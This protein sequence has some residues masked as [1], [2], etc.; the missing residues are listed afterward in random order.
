MVEYFLT[1]NLLGHF[2][3]ILQQRSNRRG[4]VAMQVPHR[5]VQRFSI[6]ACAVAQCSTVQSSAVPC[7]RWQ[8]RGRHIAGDAQGMAAPVAELRSP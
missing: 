3:Q 2:N 6:A 4:N 8:C 7:S 5:V 1:E